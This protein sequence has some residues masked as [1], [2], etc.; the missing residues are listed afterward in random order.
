MSIKVE[1]EFFKT[2]EHLPD[3]GKSWGIYVLTGEVGDS[4]VLV[5]DA[6]EDDWMLP[7]EDDD[8]VSAPEYW[9]YMPVLGSV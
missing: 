6:E 3:P 2:S 4:A 8:S 5:Y 9:A 1:V 7:G